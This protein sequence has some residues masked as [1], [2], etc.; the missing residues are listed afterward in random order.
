MITR[1]G[2]NQRFTS[3]GSVQ[4]RNTRSGVA[5]SWR[6]AVTVLGI[7]V[8]LFQECLQGIQLLVPEPFVAQRPP[9]N[10]TQRGSAQLQAVLA[11]RAV[12]ADQPCALQN[13]QVLRDG[14]Q[15]NGKPLGHVGDPGRAPGEAP[16][17]RPPGG[18]RESGESAVE[19]ARHPRMIFNPMVEY[20]KGVK[21]DARAG[22]ARSND[23]TM[24]VPASSTSTSGA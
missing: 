24:F 18:V 9:G 11:A 6:V 7:S 5:L 3:A 16:H 10:F 20:V 8:L 15:R 23:S 13:L 12:P 4:A 2:L 19:C 14:V 22:L 17:D 1:V 21:A